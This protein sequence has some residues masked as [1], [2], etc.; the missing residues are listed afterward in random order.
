MFKY[1][2][3]VKQFHTYAG[4]QNSLQVARYTV[5]AVLVQF[6]KK[7][8]R[9]ADRLQYFH[10][11]EWTLQPVW[12]GEEDSDLQ[13]EIIA[14]FSLQFGGSAAGVPQLRRHKRDWV[15]PPIKLKEN[16]DYTGTPHVS[17]VRNS[18]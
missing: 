2:Q 7:P 3:N 18:L 13:F 4:E 17:K 15:I 10:A 6:V 8:N 16:F 12:T 9:N 11:D 1:F 5:S 14:V